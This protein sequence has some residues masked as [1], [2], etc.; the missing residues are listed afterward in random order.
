MLKFWRFG[1]RARISRL[2]DEIVKKSDTAHLSL[3]DFSRGI[4]I[5]EDENLYEQRQMFRNLI[6]EARELDLKYRSYFTG[7]KESHPNYEKLQNML[8]LVYNLIDIEIDKRRGYSI[9][10]YS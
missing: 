9:P 8:H 5:V 2:E 4:S 3:F 6:R 1:A 7:K 10:V